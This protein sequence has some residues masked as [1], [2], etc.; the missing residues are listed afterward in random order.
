[1]SDRALHPEDIRHLLRRLSFAATREQMRDLL[2]LNPSE[3]FKRIWSE[4]WDGPL[5]DGPGVV[6]L[7][8]TDSAGE[9][10]A[11]ERQIRALREAW[12]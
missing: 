2:G 11:Q 3:A 10:D 4:S 1:M 12:L 5:T 7:R 8:S 6:A 9:H